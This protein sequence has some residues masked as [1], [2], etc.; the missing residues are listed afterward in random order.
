[1]KPWRRAQLT[2][3]DKPLFQEIPIITIITNIKTLVLL[4]LLLSDF[5]WSELFTRTC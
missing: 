2:R 1:M 4:L 3:L 5:Y